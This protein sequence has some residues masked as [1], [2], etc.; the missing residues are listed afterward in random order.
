MHA[1]PRMHTHATHTR[2]THTYLNLIH[3][4][5]KDDIGLPGR[6]DCVTYITFLYSRWVRW[7]STYEI[8]QS[9]YY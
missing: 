2:H 5:P 8:N 7:D 3:S 4:H 6:A 9:I 1:C